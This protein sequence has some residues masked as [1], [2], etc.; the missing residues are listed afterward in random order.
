MNRWTERQIGIAKREDDEK[1]DHGRERG[2][3]SK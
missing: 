1:E 2:R 3:I